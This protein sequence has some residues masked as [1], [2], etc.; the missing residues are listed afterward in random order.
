[1]SA[2]T[3]PDTLLALTVQTR[4][5]VY[6]LL[7]PARP[8]QG[9]ASGRG[10]GGFWG[11]APGGA[12]P[13]YLQLRPFP[14]TTGTIGVKALAL[15][16]APLCCCAWCLVRSFGKMGHRRRVPE[17]PQTGGGVVVTCQ[18][19]LTQAIA[20]LQ[21]FSR[22]SYRALQ[23]PCQPDDVLL[24]I[25]KEEIFE[26][27]QLARGQ[28]GKMLVWTGGRAVPSPPAAESV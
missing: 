1:M 25:L 14:R 18:E 7:H 3:W 9:A 21:R 2:V 19:V 6:A 5:D 20:M 27:H 26:V 11:R 17:G 4:C 13:W 12:A 15:F 28:E 16:N 24:E 22:V 8:G 10:A 23:V